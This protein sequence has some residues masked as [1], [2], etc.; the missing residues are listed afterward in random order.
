MTLSV[1][2]ASALVTHAGLASA[3]LA[4][5]PPRP[6]PAHTPTLAQRSPFSP[7][8][9]SVGLWPRTGWESAIPMISWLARTSQDA[10]GAPFS[11][12][13]WRSRTRS[14]RR[15]GNDRQLRMRFV[16]PRPICSLFSIRNGRSSTV[17]SPE[18][19][20]DHRLRT[21]SGTNTHIK[22]PRGASGPA[23]SQPARGAADVLHPG[24]LGDRVPAGGRVAVAD[25]WDDLDR[26]TF[27]AGE[28]PSDG[29]QPPPGTS[30]R[31][32][33]P[34]LPPWRTKWVSFHFL[35]RPRIALPRMS[36]TDFD[37]EISTTA[38]GA[39]AKT[40]MIGRVR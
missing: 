3:L 38:L 30:T 8:T 13:D 36:T 22:V 25:P 29:R 24:E 9:E 21:K 4:P 10:R 2:R 37:V 11:V 17:R 28:R 12:H 35:M 7:W 27:A 1:V 40:L 26:A 20:Q 16:V 31:V 18:G 34:G 15:D 6:A 39:T 5:R 33:G 19:H 23:L 14:G 32:T